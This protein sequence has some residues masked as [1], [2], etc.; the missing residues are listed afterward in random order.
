MTRW[1]HS[2]H[3]Q[4]FLWAVLPVTLAI[5]AVGFTGIYAHQQTMRDF[6][7]ERNEQLARLG[8]RIVGDGLSHG[9]VSDDGGGLT[10]WLTSMVGD[11]DMGLVV[12]D[13]Q[14]IVLAHPDRGL[15][16]VSLAADPG[17]AI[18][19]SERNGSSV[20]TGEDGGLVLVAYTGL[21]PA[22]WVVIVA[23]PV[24]DLIGPILRLPS[25]APIAAVAAGLISLLVLVFGWLTIVRPLQ[26]LAS[27]A[28]QVTW[29]DYSAI[30]GS[31]G[32][33]QEVRDLHS[34]LGRMVERIRDYEAGVRD[35]L[36]AV[37]EGQEAERE[38]LAHELHDGP[39]QEL[40]ALSQQAELA[41]HLLDRGESQRARVLLAET[42]QAELATVEGLRRVIRNLRPIYLED[43]GLVPA[44]Q[45]LVAQAEDRTQAQVRF[46]PLGEARRYSP[47]V[48]LAVY[49][50]AQEALSNAVHHADA[51]N[52]DVTLAHRAPGLT[53]SVVDDGRGFTPPSE[54]SA[55]TA[56]GHFGLVGMRERSARLGGTLD[57]QT[58]PGEGTRVTLRLPASRAERSG[59]S[60][61]LP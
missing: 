36:G 23:E 47:E 15:V 6:V 13:G 57:I 34:S 35:Y 14:G 55:L 24:E 17:V 26:R 54:A 58:S 21:E 38:R 22:D 28:D 8:A 2:L 33:V 1:F 37:T 43:L 7:A 18:A 11:E 39:V 49:R 29:G 61:I 19:L 4:L 51:R 46:E 12:L 5:V 59:A 56:G 27:A 50:I 31:V 44:L 16:G 48:E 3:A 53:L 10:E 45:M 32:G 30:S 52:I 42:R 20:I 9:A 60:A 40:I 25:V 41:Q